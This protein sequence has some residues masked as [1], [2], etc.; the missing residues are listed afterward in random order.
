MS[1]LHATFT[2]GAPTFNDV[3]VPFEPKGVYMFADVAP[4]GYGA[5]Y[6]LCQGVSDFTRHRSMAHS[7]RNAIALT[8]GTRCLSRYRTDS[9]CFI[10]N[11]F[12]TAL[13]WVTSFTISGGPDPAPWTLRFNWSNVTAA[14]LVH[15]VIVGGSGVSFRVG[16]GIIPLGTGIQTYNITW[17]LGRPDGL[18]GFF[19]GEFATDATNNLTSEMSFAMG[20]G[21]QA[22]ASRGV[23]NRS[24]SA[25]SPS[26]AYRGQGS[27]F[28]R[29]S[30]NNQMPYL[31]CDLPA[32]AS[33]HAD[34]FALNRSVGGLANR[35]FFY[36]AI[37]GPKRPGRHGY[38]PHRRR[39]KDNAAALRR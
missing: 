12:G 21:S 23:A 11:E 3:S 2:K 9:P 4:A 25:A 37:K 5:T 13:S 24:Q 34:G 27:Q 20:L 26:V 8:N 16:S 33:W 29:P 22:P 1:V 7:S 14:G 17:G 18:L 39:G 28:L 30:N 35:V 36:A 31:D 10:V 15:V 6:A 32:V 19:P 38:L